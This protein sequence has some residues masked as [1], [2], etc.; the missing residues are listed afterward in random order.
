M[1]ALFLE[2]V[3]TVI[4]KSLITF[5]SMFFFNDAFFNYFFFVV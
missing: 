2:Y 1:I 4:S 3:F 5:K